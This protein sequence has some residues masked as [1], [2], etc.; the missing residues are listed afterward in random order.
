MPM[1]IFNSEQ[2][3]VIALSHDEPIAST[4]LNSEALTS[5]HLTRKAEVHNYRMGAVYLWPP[6]IYGRTFSHQRSFCKFPRSI[7]C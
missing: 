2:C 4:Q 3:G 5:C 7:K 1:Y 6:E